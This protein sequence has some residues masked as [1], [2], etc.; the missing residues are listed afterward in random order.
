MLS[1]KML[2]ALNDQIQH[3]LESAY[4]YLAMSAYFQ[5]NNYPG[6]AQWMR[7]QYEEELIHTFRF[8][9]FIHSR[10][11]RVT[12]Q[13]IP[14]P[15]ADYNS[16]LAAFENALAHEEK[17]TGDI[18]R[19]YKLAIEENDYPSLSFLQW[20][21][22]EQVEEEENVGA[23]VE[24]LKRIGGSEQGLLMLDRELSQRQSPAAPVE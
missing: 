9:D 23:V 20:F 10:G 2:T 17:I 18:N 16:P 13:A 22:D 4:I 7:A 5:A 24:D 6:F 3:E 21:I 15:P 14:A 11:S 19:L 12:L 1:K 8:Y